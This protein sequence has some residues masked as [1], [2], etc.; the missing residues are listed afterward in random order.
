MIAIISRADE[1]G[2][3]PE[4]GTSNRILVRHYKTASGIRRF[5]RKYSIGRSFCIEYFNCIQMRYT[6]PLSTE[7]FDANG[8][9]T[10]VEGVRY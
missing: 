3:I 10:R 7:W 8:N 6:K 2:R 1:F 5:A 9:F 4:V